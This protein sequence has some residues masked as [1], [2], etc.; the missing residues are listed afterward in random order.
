[1]NTNKLSLRVAAMRLLC[2]LLTMI[3]FTMNATAFAPENTANTAKT[4]SYSSMSAKVNSAIDSAK[5]RI[6]QLYDLDTALLQ[7]YFDQAEAKLEELKV[8]SGDTSALEAEIEELC[9]KIVMAS[10]ESRV[11]SARA[12]WHRPGESDYNAIQKTVSTFKSCGINLVFVESF[13]HGC[14]IYASDDIEIP[15]HPS[16]VRSYTDTE[17]GIVYNDYLSA[18]LACCEEYGIEVHAWVENFYVGVDP[19]TKIVADHPD[20]VMYNDDGTYLQR[21]EGGPYIFIDP[22]NSEVQD[23]L[24]HFYN[25]MLQKNPG[26]RGL[27]LDYIRY[28]VSNKAYDT[29]YTV[30]AMVG[31]YESLGKTFSKEQLSDRTKMANKFK[32]LFKKEYLVGGQ[33][34]ADQNYQLWVEY[35]TNII[36]DYVQR[37]KNEVKKPNDII[38]STAVFASMNESLNSKKADWQKWYRNGWIDIATPMAYYSTA[39]SV[40]TNVKN[41]ISIGGNNCLYYTGLACSY[42]GYPA[43][44]NKEFVE[45]SYKAGASGYVIFAS[46][47]IIGHPDVQLA[48]GSGVGRKNGVLPHADIGEILRVSFEDILDKADRL[49]VPAGDMTEQQRSELAAGFEQILKKPYD[50][51]QEI[52]SIYAG[53]NTVKVILRSYATGY[54]YD[55]I[56]QQL[57]DLLTILDT[58]YCMKLVAEA[59]CETPENPETPETP[60]NP[61]NP[62]IPETSEPT[63]GPEAPEEP[64]LNFFQRIWQ[65]IVSFFQNL[66]GKKK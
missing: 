66:F 50:S 38:L 21:K 14:T 60:E 64:K 10:A 42:S 52:R 37:V 2:L 49:Y 39:N 25:D 32:Q 1:M 11:V 26:L 56:H 41:M 16:L 47:Q 5:S 46:G 4:N 36:T 15:Y 30:A 55:R 45:A 48:L 51:A 13:Y 65:A 24:I 7:S 40:H 53:V 58:R 62:E 31:F 44:Y 43:W 9:A 3:M 61:E 6:T 57:T 27:N 59:D 23:T 19:N 54:S 20:W 12:T 29:G 22:A 18:F 8:A 63:E 35:R 34:E 33:A 17:K 28:P